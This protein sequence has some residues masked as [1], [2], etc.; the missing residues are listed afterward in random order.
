[1]SKKNDTHIALL[2]MCKDEEKRIEV[3][4]ESVKDTVKSIV[5]YDTGSTDNT[6]SIL[7]NFCEKNNIVL[8]L[9]EGSF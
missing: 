5:C 3:T 9:K 7:K 1:M 2:I 8:R 4:L 6:I